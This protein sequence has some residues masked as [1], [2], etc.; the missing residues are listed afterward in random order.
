MKTDFQRMILMAIF[1]LS[2]FMLWERWQA[3]HRPPPPV[4]SAVEAPAGPGT[5]ASAAR[6][7]VPTAGAS[8]AKNAPPGAAAS[9]AANVPASTAATG[10]AVT[11]KTDLYSATIDTLG[12]VLT[13]VALTKHRN[14]GDSDQPYLAL[15][16][17]ADRTFVAQS[18][19]DGTGLPNHYTT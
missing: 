16:R 1:A 6:N 3:E 18:G 10:Q 4:Q 7:D 5:P 11:I 8:A 13:Q 2:A 14:A 12:G 19:L 9:G 17:N 15:Q